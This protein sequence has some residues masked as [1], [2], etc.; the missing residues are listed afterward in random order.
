MR[1]RPANRITHEILNLSRQQP[2]LSQ[3]NAPFFLFG[4]C[5]DRGAL[6]L[7]DTGGGGGRLHRS[8]DAM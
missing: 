6:Y 7:E 4:A 3:E 8:S 5:S 2:P 1:H